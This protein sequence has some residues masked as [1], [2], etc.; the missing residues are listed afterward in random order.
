[1]KDYSISIR[2]PS[3][4]PKQWY[5][6]NS[7]NLENSDV[8]P[9]GEQ[10]TLNTYVMVN[11]PPSVAKANQHHELQELHG[12]NREG[13]QSYKHFLTMTRAS[14]GHQCLIFTLNLIK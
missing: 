1:M 5:K 10:H 9:S 14:K 8:I 11:E 4:G 12:H 2:W 3:N 13:P 7:P 6:T